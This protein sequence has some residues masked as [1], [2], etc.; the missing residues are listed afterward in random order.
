MTWGRSSTRAGSR[1]G[2]VVTS[3]VVTRL[4]YPGDKNPSR[5]SPFEGENAKDHPTWIECVGS[6][7]GVTASPDSAAALAA[8]ER[9][10]NF[11]VALRVLP[12]RYREA[13][14]DVYALARRIDDAGDDPAAGVDE[15]LARLERREAEVSRRHG[16]TAYERPF[17]DLIEANRLDQTVRR[18]PAYADLLGYCR[19][20]ADPI[21]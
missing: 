17:L 10:E 6:T 16:G 12:R 3:D 20:S 13:L 15:R 8:L 11:P 7:P 9:A 1:S 14:R 19:R 18:Y 5:Q 4:L 2:S 21:G